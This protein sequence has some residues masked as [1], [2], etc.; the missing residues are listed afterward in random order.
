MSMSVAVQ[1]VVDFSAPS[2]WGDAER[3]GVWLARG[4]RVVFVG[5][6]R[7]AC[8]TVGGEGA[9]RRMGACDA[10]GIEEGGWFSASEEAVP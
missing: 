6:R 2:F 7:G 9:G 3:F 4:M 10:A 1:G 8:R 5:E